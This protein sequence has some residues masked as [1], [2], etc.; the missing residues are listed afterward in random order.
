VSVHTEYS[1]DYLSRVFVEAVG[2]RDVV[3][4]RV[5][6]TVHDART[7]FAGGGAKAGHQ[8]FPIVD[9]D[10]L[11]T[12]VLT[13]RDILSATAAP[14]WR[15]GELIHRPPVVVFDDSTLRDAADQMVLEEVGRVPV[16]RR[17]APRRVIGI[18]SRSDLLAAH[19]PRL[20]EAREARRTRLSIFRA[21]G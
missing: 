15:L 7:W 17:D 3:T 19:A 13:R 5:D 21:T 20:K 8:G 18:L 9:A 10:G 2:L 4:L 12:G 11:L 1:V 16:V 6:M 14:E